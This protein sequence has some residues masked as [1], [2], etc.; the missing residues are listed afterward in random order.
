MILWLWLLLLR[1]LFLDT[2]PGGSD[3][4]DDG[5]SGDDDGD[6][7]GDPADTP[8]DDA[9]ATKNPKARIKSLLGANARLI[10]KLKERDQRI[11]ELEAGTN[12]GVVQEARLAAAFWRHVYTSD[13]KL[14]DAETALELATNK[15]FFDTVSFADDGAVEGMAE[16]CTRL[17]ERY[18]Y[19]VSEEDDEEPPA[20]TSL[21]SP[22]GRQP[23]TRNKVTG[24]SQVTTA[25]MKERFPIL[26]RRV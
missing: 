13:V 26:K 9:E 10:K 16:A 14:T 6:G 8:P 19:L 1:F 21:T 4:D 25:K 7:D 12:D 17:T 24:A 2:D 18:P 15:G 23:L 22:S 3:G 20:P 5:D 11:E